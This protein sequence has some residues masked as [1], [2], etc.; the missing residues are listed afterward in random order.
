[1]VVRCAAKIG[2]N[3]LHIPFLRVLRAMYPRQQIHLVHHEKGRAV[4]EHWPFTD[5]RIG[6]A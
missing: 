6:I 1:M 4:F 3:L 5:K 2:D